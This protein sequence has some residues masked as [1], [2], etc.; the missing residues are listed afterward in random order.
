MIPFLQAFTTVFHCFINVYNCF[1]TVLQGFSCLFSFDT[2]NGC[3]CDNPLGGRIV[4]HTSVYNCL[5]TVL[6]VITSKYKCFT[7]VYSCFTTVLQVFTTVFSLFYKGK[8]LSAFFYLAAINGCCCD[9]A[10]HEKSL[11]IQV[12]TTVFPLFYKCLQLFFYCF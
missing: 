11:T 6:Q 10:L 7:S 4:K 1:Y 3:C 9:N 2:I 12:F 5:S 8:V